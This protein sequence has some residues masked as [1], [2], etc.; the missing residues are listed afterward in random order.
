M[1]F[2]KEITQLSEQETLPIDGKAGL[3]E[4]LMRLRQKFQVRKL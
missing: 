2:G 3:V 4:I 1:R